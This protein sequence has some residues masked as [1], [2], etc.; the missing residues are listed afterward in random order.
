MPAI[1]CVMLPDG[2]HPY[3]TRQ[4]GDYTGLSTQ[5]T[6]REGL[7]NVV[8]PEEAGSLLEKVRT[9]TA[10]GQ[11]FEHEAR[12]RRAADGEYRW[13]LVRATPLLDDT[14]TPVKLYGMMIDIEDRM[15]AKEAVRR[16]EAYLAQAQKLTRTGSWAYKPGSVRPSYFSDEM[17]RLYGLSPEDKPPDKDVI[18]SRVV[19]GDFAKWCGLAKQ[20]SNGS[21]KAPAEIDYGWVAPDGSVRHFHT[22]I[23]PVLD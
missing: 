21:R 2:T 20:L 5:Q 14:G 13:F 15:R 6:D 3:L 1:A 7:A 23:S 17:F 10:S 8:H 11:A 22:V 4:W 9:A 18:R 16:S 12:L 19:P